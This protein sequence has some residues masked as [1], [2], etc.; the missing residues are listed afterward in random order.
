M[1][2]F[3]SIFFHLTHNFTTQITIGDL[4]FCH[5]LRKRNHYYL[6]LLLYLPFIF[7]PVIWEAL[8]STATSLA[9]APFFMIGWFSYFF[10]F[11][12]LLSSI[13][14]WFCYDAP[15]LQILFYTV[16]AHIIQH[17]TYL[18]G[19][20][21]ENFFPEMSPLAN[22][23]MVL[24]IDIIIWTITFFLLIQRISKTRTAVPNRTL[25]AFVTI[26]ATMVNILNYWAW[27][28]KIQTM[29]TLVY[30]LLSSIF[31]LV[32]QF[33][34][35]ERSHSQ[36]EK[37]TFTQLFRTAESQQALSADTI[38]LLNRKCHDMK[39]Q[40]AALRQ[41]H[42]FDEREKSLA[43]LE[44]TISIYDNMSQTGNPALDTLLSEKH[45]QCHANHIQF[46]HIV[47][48]SLF[49]FM[50]NTDLYAL[51][52]NALDNA[53]ESVLKEEISNRIITMRGVQ[54]NGFLTIVIDN[55][56][57]T[58]VQFED[59]LPVTTKENK[60]YHGFGVQ[61]IRFIT[62][63]YHGKLSFRYIENENRF[64]LTI[65]FPLSQD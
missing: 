29:A 60:D 41:A 42:N 35:C 21:F 23:I 49:H 26:S 50:D 20:I 55:Y 25:L 64:V 59:G 7:A 10:I 31:L 57:S 11:M 19:S 5:G 34:L 65:I 61:S 1:N 46:T 30:E 18:V 4:L 22:G 58:P 47:D 6:R 27:A 24:V 17:T 32:I 53:I 48:G 2:F 44:E 15:Y 63:S 16:A 43:E 28:F 45:L 54:K 33:D 56:C 8:P 51:L 40:I 9:R 12:V 36:L 38:S 13:I 14:T 52:G 3:V 37:E 39:H 62:Q